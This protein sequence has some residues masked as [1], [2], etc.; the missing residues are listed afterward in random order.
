MEIHTSCGSDSKCLFSLN[1][2]FILLLIKLRWT[3][4][5]IRRL[6]EM[7]NLLADRPFFKKYKKKIIFYFFGIFEQLDEF[8]FLP[9]P[10]GFPERESHGSNGQL[11][12]SLSS[13]AVEDFPAALVFHARPEAMSLFSFQVIGLIC[14]FHRSTSFYVEVKLYYSKKNAC[15]QGKA[16]WGSRF[17]AKKAPGVSFSLSMVYNARGGHHEIS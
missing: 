1:H 2:S 14:S 6:T 5:P 11:L 16:P 13:S 10:L 9:D 8:G 17:Q 7:A 3:E 4:L 15:C 12:S